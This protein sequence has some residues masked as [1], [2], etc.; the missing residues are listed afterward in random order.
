VSVPPRG[1][2]CS[3][4][5]WLVCAWLVSS[6]S[7]LARAEGLRAHLSFS[8]PVGSMCPTRATLQQDVEELTGQSPFVPKPEAQIL[9]EG[10]IEELP[11]GV[12]AQLKARDAAG[13]VLGTRE[14]VAPPGECASLRAP[15]AV[16]LTMLLDEEIELAPAERARRGLTGG[17]ALVMNSGML[18]RAALGLGV[19]LGIDLLRTL[20]LRIDAT[21]WFPITAQTAS[22]LGAKFRGF[23]AAVAACPALA[24]RWLWLCTGVQ[25]S[26]VY[27]TPRGVSGPDQLR[28]LGQ[29]LLELVGSLPAG[30]V[31]SVVAGLGLLVT[32]NRPEFYYVRSDGSEA[33][34]LRPALLGA[35]LRLGFS[36]GQP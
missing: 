2:R 26:G 12:R 18:P 33:R 7:S 36:F 11:E 27:A 22:G 20:R 8:Q 34:V 14:L 10:S 3:M 21:Y 17:P 32:P 5:G 4:L 1:A 29:G 16:V 35:L 31:G 25:A 24:G 13:G 15:L 30:R 6:M 9:V 23:S 19:A 28:L